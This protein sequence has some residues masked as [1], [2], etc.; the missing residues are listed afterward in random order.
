MD[1]GEQRGW[2]R[3]VLAAIFGER[4]GDDSVVFSFLPSIRPA[5]PSIPST[6]TARRSLYP[7]RPVGSFFGY[8]GK[9]SRTEQSKA[10]VMDRGADVRVLDGGMG[11]AAK[12]VLTT[13]LAPQA[14]EVCCTRPGLKV[15]F[16]GSRRTKSRI[17]SL[18]ARTTHTRYFKSRG[19]ID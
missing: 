4:G 14:P 2:T 9:A 5:N 10:V 17:D 13:A 1:R 19:V 16:L 3:G 12:L 11:V 18:F 15:F 7:L 8:C 6:Q